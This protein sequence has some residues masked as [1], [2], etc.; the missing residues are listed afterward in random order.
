MLRKGI[1]SGCLLL[2]VFML[3][4]GFNV[5][6][7][8]PKRGG[9]V[10]IPNYGDPARL[11]PHGET[12]LSV[13]QAHAGIYSSLLQW[14]PANPREIVPDLAVS[15][16]ASPDGTSYTFK[17]RQGVKWHDGEPF[18][19]ADVQASF[20]RLLDPKFRSPRCGALLRPIVE[21]AETV[22]T[23]TVRIHLKFPAATFIRSIASSWCRIVAKHVLEKYGDLRKVEAQIGTGPFKFKRY[24]RGSVIEWERNPDYYDPRY[25]YVD[26]VKI[27]ILKGT[28]RL[29]AAAKTGRIMIS[30]TWPGL[31]P[32]AAEELRTVRGDKVRL[33]P[34]PLNNLAMLV[35]NSSKPPFDKRDMRRAVHLAIDRHE[36]FTKL[37]DGIGAPCRILDPKI[38][39]DFG[40]PAEE[41][42]SLPGCRKDKTED[43]A[44]AKR[45]VAKHYPNGLD[46]EVVTR[47]IGDYL[48]RTELMV[49][50]LRKVGIRGKIKAYDSASGIAQYRKGNFVLI[51]AQD[52]GMFLPDPSAPFG[53]WFYSKGGFNFGKWKDETVDR[54]HEAG[55]R[56]RDT[57]KRRKIYHELQRHILTQDAP[58]AVIGGV[59][60]WH[61]IDNRLHNYTHGLTMFDNNTFMKVWLD[62]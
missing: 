26:G 53:V 46:V 47:S 44:E 43:L 27:F 18:T 62:Q 57:A 1:I 39:G 60:A 2:L 61:F 6:A 12:V 59:Y 41:I 11:D 8:E 3:A 32:N 24:E 29:L 16:E 31:S 15:Y 21:R 38:Y 34:D 33:Y 22:D 19:A 42:E 36:L 13:Q 10:S 52:A 49:A 7:Q 51:G 35:V 23:Y 48:Q 37:H 14:D 50:Q 5:L 54:L 30:Q 28:A 4:G 25:P 40:L 58:G 45:L 9:I 20:D 17:L 55:L 56:E